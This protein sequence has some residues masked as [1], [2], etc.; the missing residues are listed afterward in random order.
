MSFDCTLN[1]CVFRETFNYFETNYC[2]TVDAAY[3]QIPNSIHLLNCS[4]RLGEMASKIKLSLATKH[5][6][7]KVFKGCGRQ[8]ATERKQS[9]SQILKR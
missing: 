2:T 1:I 3:L 7:I 9:E 8:K 6:N 5:Q 4:L